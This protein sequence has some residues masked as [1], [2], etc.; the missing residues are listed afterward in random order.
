MYIYICLYIHI[1]LYIY[2]YTYIIDKG[3]RANLKRTYEDLTE[4]EIHYFDAVEQG[5]AGIG[6]GGGGDAAKSRAWKKLLFGLTFFHACIQ[7]YHVHLCVCMC[8]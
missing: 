4:A 7:V 2:I 1:H 3:L 5:G 8:F 6:D